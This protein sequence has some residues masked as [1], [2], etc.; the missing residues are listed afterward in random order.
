MIRWSRW[1][2]KPYRRP[3][4]TNVFL[5]WL[6]YSCRR[7][8]KRLRTS[9]R[10]PRPTW[11]C[12]RPRLLRLHWRQ[13]QRQ[14][15]QQSLRQHR[16]PRLQRTQHRHLPLQSRLHRL[17]KPRRSLR[18]KTPNRHRPP[19]RLHHR[20]N[21]PCHHRASLF[22]PCRP[23]LSNRQTFR[24]RVARHRSRN[25]FWLDP[26]QARLK[27]YSLYRKNPVINA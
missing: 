21:Q 14:R 1:R 15:Q 27:S 5:P 10:N 16:Q 20:L 24:D 19:K 2:A 8:R 6:S 4:S 18:L 26:R 7:K 11:V 22:R 13:R 25:G 3:S 12:L 23:P 17:L 9:S